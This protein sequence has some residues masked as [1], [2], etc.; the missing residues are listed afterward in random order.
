L[1]PIFIIELKS[2]FQLEVSKK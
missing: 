1:L 2:K